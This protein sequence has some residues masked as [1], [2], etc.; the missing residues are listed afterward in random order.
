MSCHARSTWRQRFDWA[1]EWQAPGDVEA[2]IT[3][4][5]SRDAVVLTLSRG[6]SHAVFGLCPCFGT[7]ADVHE[8]MDR[9]ARRFG[10]FPTPE[11]DPEPDGLAV[12]LESAAAAFERGVAEAV[13]CRCGGFQ[14]L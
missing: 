3:A 8:A 9:E 2:Q 1:A 12:K 4:I 13:E 10:E 5:P 6:E 14:S 11:P 7:A